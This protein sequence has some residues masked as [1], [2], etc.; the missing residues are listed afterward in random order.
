MT[1]YSHEYWMQRA[2]ELARLAQSKGEV[3]VGAVLVKDNVIIG[4]GHNQVI[5]LNDPSAHAEIL[6]LREAATLLQNYR[7]PQTTLYV[8]IE[9]CSM[10]AGAIVHAR[11][12]HLVFAA[13]EPKAGV[14]MSQGSFLDNN[15]L[16]HRVTFEA[17]V[18]EQE[19]SQLISDFF[20]VKRKK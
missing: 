16:N 9:P 10:C 19:S 13:T 12:N 8:T 17:G 1:E 18:L 15:F 14:I 6:A 11:V 7:L 3:P 5:T 4:E 20:K 2:L